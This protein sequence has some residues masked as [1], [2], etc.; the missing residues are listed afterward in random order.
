MPAICNGAGGVAPTSYRRTALNACTALLAHAHAR[1]RLI[2]SIIRLADSCIPATIH[3]LEAKVVFGTDMKPV[4]AVGMNCMHQARI[5]ATG[6]SR[7]STGTATHCLHIAEG[8]GREL[9]YNIVGQYRS[10]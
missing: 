5:T 10:D 1:T 8:E 4:T 6:V 3:S 7:V 9:E 2:Q